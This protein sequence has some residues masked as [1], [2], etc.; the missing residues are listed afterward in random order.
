MSKVRVQGIQV[1]YDELG[2]G[3]AVVLLHGYPF[4]RSMWL[5]QAE[6]LKESHRVIIPDLRGHGETEVTAEASIEQMAHDVASLLDTLEISRVSLGGLSMGGYVSL[7]FYR[8]F[9]LRVRSLI[10]A[11][12]RAQADTE[13][14]RKTRAVQAEKALQE[15]MEG[16]ADSLLQKLLAPETVARRPEIVKRIREMMVQ[17]KPEGAA[18]AL[19]AMAQ[20]PDQ[21]ELLS[22]IIAPTMIVVGRE[23]S[24]TPV[25]DSEMMHREIG[26]SRLEIIEGAGHVSNLEKPKEFNEALLRFLHDLEG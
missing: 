11:D 2:S 16:I 24:I 23:D 17:T 18:A 14:I 7:A 19:A 13:E 8:S 3:P 21:T 15:G 5:E 10:L 25:A 12:T 9:P 20:R 4:D 1:A 22:R 6:V 26:G